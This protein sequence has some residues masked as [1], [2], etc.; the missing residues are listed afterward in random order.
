MY[1]VYY[2]KWQKPILQKPNCK[3]RFT[4]EGIIRL[5]NDEQDAW[6]HI[7]YFFAKEKQCR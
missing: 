4:Y 2:F 7:Q 6:K 5:N 1:Q 3:K